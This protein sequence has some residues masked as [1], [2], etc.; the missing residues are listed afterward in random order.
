MCVCMCACVRAYVCVYLV[1]N[2]NDKRHR[3]MKDICKKVFF[4]IY[5]QGKIIL[6]QINV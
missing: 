4:L 6:G 1:K 3:I 2:I 5:E